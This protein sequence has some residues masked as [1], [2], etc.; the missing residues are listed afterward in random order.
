MSYYPSRLNLSKG[1][2]AGR[3]RWICVES[4]L[5]YVRGAAE[6]FRSFQGFWINPALEEAFRT[7][8]A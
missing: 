2:A 5:Q 6:L 7:S 1:G 8:D 4:A 3:L